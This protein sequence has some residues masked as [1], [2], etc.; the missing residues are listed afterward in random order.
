MLDIYHCLRYI[1]HTWHLRN[2]FRAIKSSLI[3]F[4]FWNRWQLSGMNCEASEHQQW[5]A[6]NVILKCFWVRFRPLLLVLILK[7]TPH[8]WICSR[9]WWLLRWSTNSPSFWNPKFNYHFQKQTNGPYPWTEKFS[10]RPKKLFLLISM[11]TYRR[12][13]S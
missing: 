10:Q 3:C 9:S 2:L 11:L 13:Y 6:Y 8:I 4:C 5:L 7:L 12:I 1:W